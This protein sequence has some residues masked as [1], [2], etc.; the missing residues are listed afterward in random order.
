MGS[1][2][3]NI[4]IASEVFC[5]GMALGWVKDGNTVQSF[6][7]PGMKYYLYEEGRFK[8]IDMWGGHVPHACGTTYLY[9]DESLFWAMQYSGQYPKEATELVKEALL[10]NY[11]N[12]I[13]LGGRGPA[14]L[15][16]EDLHYANVPHKPGGGIMDFKNFSGQDSVIRKKRGSDIP[17][18]QHDYSGGIVNME[19]I[20]SKN[21]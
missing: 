6:E 13:F 18:G 2:K 17:Q 1:L 3:D 10:K 21:F 14:V 15:I 19:I 16:K 8:L 9:Y 20:K 11:S 4:R 5:K 12:G 7:V